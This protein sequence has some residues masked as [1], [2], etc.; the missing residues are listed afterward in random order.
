MAKVFANKITLAAGTATRLSAALATAGFTGPMVGKFL[1]IDDY[2]LADLRR[3]D[4][5]S[6]SATVGTPI[7]GVN[8]GVYR[9]ET[10]VID[11]GAIWLFSTAGGDI[12][13]TFESA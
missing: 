1:E 13:V 8:G 7:S 10:G 6:V 9:R 12:G 5:S 2:A 3:G 11:P 4:S